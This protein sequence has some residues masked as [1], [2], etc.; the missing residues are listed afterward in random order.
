MCI[1]E[2]WLAHLS[3]LT[4]S[5][6]WIIS[7]WS[8]GKTASF[9]SILFVL[10]AIFLIAVL[11]LR[12]IANRIRNVR[13]SPCE[14][15]IES[16]WRLTQRKEQRLVRQKKYLSDAHHSLLRPK[17]YLSDTEKARSKPYIL[18][19]LEQRCSDMIVAGR[20]TAHLPEA[21]AENTWSY[22]YPH[23]SHA[24]STAKA[25]FPRT[26]SAFSM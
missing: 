26:S 23:C 17:Q 15:I 5:A 20:K 19:D 10:F 8:L 24:V 1:C 21:Y 16:T 18:Q 2:I 12:G 3:L 13:K 22:S 25:R 9:K 11:S 4:P 7:V 6:S 14:S